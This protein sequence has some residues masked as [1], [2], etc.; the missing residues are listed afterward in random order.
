MPNYNQSQNDPA[1]IGPTPTYVDQAMSPDT[2]QFYADQ[3]AAA[4]AAA[5]LAQQEAAA[6]AEKDAKI[7]QQ[8]MDEINQMFPQGFNFRGML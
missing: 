4:D 8:Q 2:T 5:L 7:R 3:Q 6:Q 1:G